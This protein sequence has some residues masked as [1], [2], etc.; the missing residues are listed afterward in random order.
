MST[1]S[2]HPIEYLREHVDYAHITK[3]LLR[4]VL[5]IGCT[6]LLIG[7]LYNTLAYINIADRDMVTQTYINAFPYEMPHMVVDPLGYASL[8]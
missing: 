4:L 1:L 5:L 6:L 7:G 2:I 8:L 3:K